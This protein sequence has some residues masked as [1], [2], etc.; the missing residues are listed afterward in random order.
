MANSNHDLTD[1]IRLHTKSHT[2]LASTR[3]HPDKKHADLEVGKWRKMVLQD[4]VNVIMTLEV[5]DH[6]LSTSNNEH[7]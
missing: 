1:Q 6:F 5:P 2:T 3:P 4:D 7:Q